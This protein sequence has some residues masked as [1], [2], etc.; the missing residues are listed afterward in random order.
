MTEILRDVRYALRAIRSSP[1]LF[2][3]I[4]ATLAV[5]IG[6]NA[7]VFSW[8]EGIVFR[9]MAGVPNQ[10]R[11][12]AVAGFHQPGDRCCVFSYPDYVDY[13]DRNAVLDGIVAGELIGPTLVDNGKAERVIGQIVTGSYFDVLRVKP[14]LGRTF[15][16]DED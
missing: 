16:P 5:A 13:R 3:T 1:G 7:T 11:I 10:D 14:Q 9:P 8:M 15:R 6:G 12:V 2:A 4:V